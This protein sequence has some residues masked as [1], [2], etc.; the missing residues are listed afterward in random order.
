MR[1]CPLFRGV[2]LSCMRAVAAVKQTSDRMIASAERQVT[3]IPLTIGPNV[4][5]LLVSILRSR[6][7]SFPGSRKKIDSLTS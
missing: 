1:H 2:R 4:G 3:V 5:R 7:I 6:E